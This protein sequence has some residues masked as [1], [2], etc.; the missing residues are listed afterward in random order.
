[1]ANRVFDGA[2]GELDE[3]TTGFLAQSQAL[4][5]ASS[6]L[7]Q[8]IGIGVAGV[9]SKFSVFSQ[10][11]VDF[12]DVTQEDPL[13]AEN[14]EIDEALLDSV[15]LS[16]A[17]DVR[18]LFNFDLTSSD[19]RVTLLSFTGDTQ[20]SSTG[21]ALNV[22]PFS[23]E[24]LLLF[25]EEAD[26]AY[27]TATRGS[28]SADAILA[29]DNTTTADGLIADA[30]NDTHLLTT[31]AG[32]SFT[33]GENY[34]FSTYVKA[35]D[36][37]NARIAFNGAAFGGT[38]IG[39]DFDLVAGTVQSTDAGVSDTTIEDAG[40]GW[41]RVS[42]K[43]TATATGTANLE[44][45]AKDATTTF[46]GDGTTV[47]SYFWGAQLED[48]TTETS[49]GGYLTTTTAAVIGATAS[50][51]IDGAADGADD[52][53]A[54]VTDSVITVNTGNAQGLQLFFSGLELPSTIQ[55][56]ITVGVGAQMY[57]QLGELLDVTTGVIDAE[58]D[59]LTDQNELNNERITEMLDRLGNPARKP[60]GTLYCDGISH[61]HGQQHYGK[62]Q[63]N[64]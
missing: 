58:I 18:K 41:Y 51:N 16:N 17:D 25:S 35:G 59:E 32:E 8:I 30:T 61:C 22:Q 38:L 9:D 37:N 54:T 3:E 42:I 28:V 11:G 26:N 64:H 15:L 34:I 24:N 43:A 31:A 1:M 4:A 5:A 53:S 23:G 48:V 2:T 63:A 7:S 56:D 47:S 20:Y 10:I 33:T 6:Q 40:D 50:A 46:T 57:F 55:L 49:P 62:P 13:L 45:Y 39:A 14:M 12:V 29:P 27:W 36:R 44:R 21:Y 52:G 60:H 19:P